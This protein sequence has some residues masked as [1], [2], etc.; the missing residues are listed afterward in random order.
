MI[1]ISAAKWQTGRHYILDPPDIY[2]S[3]L[4]GFSS[5]LWWIWQT[6][7]LHIIPPFSEVIKHKH[8]V[9]AIT[10]ILDIRDIILLWGSILVNGLI[11]VQRFYFGDEPIL[12]ETWMCRLVISCSDTSRG[13]GGSRPPC[14]TKT[15]ATDHWSCCLTQ[16]TRHTPIPCMTLFH[17]FIIIIIW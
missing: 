17:H 9:W 15:P 1:N 8:T 16:S 12:M 5:V 6:S 10:I 14:V 4:I 2:Y 7:Q 11:S 3:P 13:P